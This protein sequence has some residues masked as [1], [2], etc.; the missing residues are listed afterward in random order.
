[1]YT[2]INESIIAGVNFLNGKIIPLYFE[3]KK[4]RYPIDEIT[5]FWKTRIG[6]DPLYHFSVK[7]RDNI[8][9][10]SYNLKTS[11]WCLEK[12]YVE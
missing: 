4:R 12:V 5:Y 2:V 7:S 6:S 11:E 8:Y 10:I 3:W 9:E 1:M